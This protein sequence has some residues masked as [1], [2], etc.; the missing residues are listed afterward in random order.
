MKTSTQ[1]I[2]ASGKFLWAISFC[3]F[4]FGSSAV[5]AEESSSE[6]EWQMGGDIYLWGASLTSTAP[7]GA[8]SELD[9]GQILDNLEMTF[10]G[11]LW[12][13]KDR[14]TVAADVIYMNLK[15]STDRS[16][17]MGGGLDL[18]LGASLQLKSWI[19][20]PTVSYNLSDNSYKGRFELLAGVRYLDLSADL[21]A[22]ISGSSGP[23]IDRSASQSGSNWDFVAGFRARA[24]LGSNWY[25]PFYFDA[26]TGDSKFTWQGLAGIGYQ[27]KKVNVIA[28]YRYL[29]YEFDDEPG[30]LL[31]EL[32]IKGPLLGASFRF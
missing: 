10:M 27:F 22:N 19:V 23:I 4:C 7:S 16:L 1:L 25:L 3:V 5:F 26:G 17:G 13:K 14:W 29:K 21:E 2:K 11:G 32:E 12:G 24:N 28:S 30:D 8:S 9:F 20:T 6:S 31:A 18:T 15:G